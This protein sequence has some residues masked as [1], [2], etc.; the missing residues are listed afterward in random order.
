M[1][2]L[3]SRASIT[4]GPL[5]KLSVGD[6]VFINQ[7]VTIHAELDVTIGNRVEIGDG[8]TIYDTNFH[9]VV[10][11]GE[12]K[13]GPV[14]IQDDVWLGNGVLILPGVSVGRGSVVGAGAVV[15]QDIPQG[16]LAVGSPAK[17]VRGFDVPVDYQRR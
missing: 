13:S 1:R 9:P 4:V 15:T 12:V 5:G 16:S 14:N 17:V 7:G 8:V 10:P 11:G 2:S 3:Q 6:S